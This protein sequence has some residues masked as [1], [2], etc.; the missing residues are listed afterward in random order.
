MWHSND[1]F[2]YMFKAEFIL[3]MWDLCGILMTCSVTCLKLNL[4]LKCDIYVAL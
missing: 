3:K 4:F 1:M 2:H